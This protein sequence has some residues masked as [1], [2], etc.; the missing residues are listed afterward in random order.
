MLHVNFNAY[1]S[2]VT[3]SLYQWD[4]NQVLNIIGLNLKSAPEIHFCNANMDRAIVRRSR[5]IN[6]TITV[7]IPNSLLQEAFTIKAYIGIYESETFKVIE[8]VEI[9]VIGRARPY[10]YQFEDTDGEIYSFKALEA[11]IN[12]IDPTNIDVSMFAKKDDVVK[13]VGDVMTGP[14]TLS[15]DPTKNLHAVPKQYADKFASSVTLLWSNASPTSNFAEQ[16]ILI[17]NIQNYNIVIV[18]YY[19][20]TT[21]QNLYG[22]A[23]LYRNAKDTVNYFTTIG[24]WV[25]QRS[26]SFVSSGISINNC[27]GVSDLKNDHLIPAEIYGIKLGG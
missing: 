12:A 25:C 9:P 1:N 8:T 18:S 5:L 13:K 27:T 2:Y 24:S 22:N 11:K 14:L 20:S 26:C 10:D 21:S 19:T 4:I 17:D 16:T 3:D 23:V 6:G 7:N 15:G